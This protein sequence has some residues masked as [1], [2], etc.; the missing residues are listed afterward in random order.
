MGRPAGSRSFTRNPPPEKSRH[1]VP[2]A[3]CPPV[4]A[5]PGTGGQAASGTRSKA[6]RGPHRY[7][8]F[9][10]LLGLYLTIQGY[11][12]RDGDQAYRLPL[13]LHRQ[14]PA[15]YAA[16]PF[17]RAFDA[18]NPHRGY[19]AL[20]D[21]TSRPL[22]LSAALFGLF[23]LTF[24]ATAVGISRL[25]RA[26]WP[27]SGAGVGVVAVG[28]VLLDRAGNV[29][30]NHLFDGM[31][32]DRLIGFGLGWIALASAV[33]APAGRA[34]VGAAA[35]GLAALI[36]PSVGLQLAMLA[37][38]GWVAWA[39]WPARTGVGW[40]DAGRA[41]LS[42][43]IALLPAALLHGGGGAAMF[44][45]LSRADYLLLG[46]YVQSPQHMLP[47]LWRRPQWLAWGATMLLAVVALLRK[48]PPPKEYVP[49]V[50]PAARPPVLAGA[51]TGGQAASG[52]PDA[53]IRASFHPTPQGKR[54]L[55]VEGGA[56]SG[57]W[58]I[59]LLLA[60]NLAGLG[61][62]WVAVEALHDLRATLFQPFRMATIAR[63]LALVL[64]AG[65]VRALW[66]RGDA[67]GKVRATLLA[68]GLT[69][70][71]ALVVVAAAELAVV[72]AGWIAP[73]MARGVGLCVLGV[74]LGFLARHDTESGHVPI[75]LALGG[76]AAWTIATRARS[77]GWTPRRLAWAL[78]AAWALPAAA[79]VAPLLLDAGRGPG[80]A[81]VAALADR[82]RF[83][84][85][86]TDDVERLALWCR[87]NTPASA[88]FVGPPGPKTFRLWSRRAVAFNRAASPYHA[89]GLADWS[90]R[91]RDH[92]GFRGSTAEFAASYL[93]D[94]QGLERRYQAMTDA[95]RAALAGRQGATHVLAAAP[96][97][98]SSVDPAGP[99]EL[100]RV[101]GR[102]AVYRV[103]SPE[104]LGDFP[105]TSRIASP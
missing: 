85:V 98:G 50:P 62:A 13:L 91:F 56:G 18:F 99:L 45:G 27:D 80:R 95:D 9:A 67:E 58:R 73:R 102:Y 35:I 59:A 68:V 81:I 105:E 65:H 97:A 6:D 60:I 78:A 52:T 20:L 57:A 49:R 92:V 17:V 54:P 44:R 42:L 79:L 47:H 43:M 7:L 24:A 72:A 86:P 75:L 88:R 31:L 94:R 77:M 10:I 39:A 76:L 66:G 83:G 30:T 69:G 87:D 2:L 4:P 74:G 16:D 1:R 33:A 14:D 3:A 15:L 40:Q 32:L 89:A 84:E 63:G 37:G 46:A 64:L 55:P 8:P 51:D 101:E 96:A 19:L 28:L 90:A 36:H 34:W 71:W 61:L 38:A 53:S 26:A 5:T 82:C 25:A 93:A 41:I 48:G 21:W 12:S 104:N 29:G 11:H 23:C 100:L 70:D 22:G 103:R